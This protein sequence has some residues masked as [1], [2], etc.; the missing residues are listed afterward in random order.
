MTEACSR[1][2]LKTGSRIEHEV[3]GREEA[4]AG[5]RTTRRAWWNPPLVSKN[6][7]PSYDPWHGAVPTTTYQ[8]RTDSPGRPRHRVRLRGQPERRLPGVGPRRESLRRLGEASRP[9]L[10]CTEAAG[11]ECF[12]PL[13]WLLRLHGFYSVSE[14]GVEP[15][16]GTTPHCLGDVRIESHLVV[17]VE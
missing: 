7:T 6:T 13:V 9:G 2:G 15:C 8:G 16:C 5:R 1:I 4:V 12:H 3:K 11:L 17:M 10:T 14:G